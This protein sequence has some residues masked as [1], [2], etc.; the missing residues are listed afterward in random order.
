MHRF[1]TI[2]YYCDENGLFLLTCDVSPSVSGPGVV[3][4]L[5]SPLS[6]PELRA[7]PP[8][9][10]TRRQPGLLLDPGDKVWL[11]VMSVPVAMSFIELDCL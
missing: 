5:W 3:Y 1:E 10:A 11:E 4:R 8:V 6:A 9:T 7:P 2:Y